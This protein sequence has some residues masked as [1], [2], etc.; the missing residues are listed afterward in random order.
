MRMLMTTAEVGRRL[1]VTPA[2][3]RLMARR[4]ELPI[5][6]Q[7]ASGVRLFEESAVEALRARRAERTRDAVSVA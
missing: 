3:V 7:S 2:T 1:D 6:V 4:G 5:A